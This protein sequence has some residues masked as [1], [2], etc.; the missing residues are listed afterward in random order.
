MIKTNN[1]MALYSS[2]GQV[3]A[4]TITI[5]LCA[6]DVHDVCAYVVIFIDLL[7]SFCYYFATV[8]FLVVFFLVVVL[9]SVC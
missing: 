2:N 1:N 3:N 8:L 6:L 9:S 4:I 5:S 7:Y